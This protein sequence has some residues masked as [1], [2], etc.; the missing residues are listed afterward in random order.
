MNYQLLEYSCPECGILL[1]ETAA[2]L[3]QDLFPTCIKEEC[4]KC[5]FYHTD[6]EK[7]MEAAAIVAGTTHTGTAV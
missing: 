7:S 4:P 5:G 3:N 2:E 6:S 1:K